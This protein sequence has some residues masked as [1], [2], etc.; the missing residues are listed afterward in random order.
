VIEAA[1]DVI[2]AARRRLPPARSVL[3]AVSGIDGSGKGFV[4]AEIMRALEAAGLRV[5]GINI[6]GWLNLPQVRFA[7]KDPA[8]HFYR[9][10]IRFEELFAQLLIPLRDRRKVRIEADFAE[11]TATS[12]RKQRYAF[13]DV[14]VVVVEGIYLLKRE[15]RA[16]HDV[17]LWIDCSFETALERALAR[18]QEG[19]PID[20]TVRVY[21][22]IYFPAQEI[23]FARDEPRAAATAVIAN[24]PRLGG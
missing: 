1:V 15:L 24:D 16:H 14:D 4:S 23:H 2:L 5:A 22:T 7:D 21:R 13:D 6:D 8:E 19:L 17:S 20:E 12:Y 9:H 11:E 10:A 18:G 3:A